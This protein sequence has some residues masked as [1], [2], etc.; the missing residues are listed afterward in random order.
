MPSPEEL[1]SFT[2]QMEGKKPPMIQG[3]PQPQGQ[4]PETL[5]EKQARLSALDKGA[6]TYPQ[7]TSFQDVYS[8]KAQGS[9]G[10]PL[11]KQQL[12]KDIESS[13]NFIKD[14]MLKGGVTDTT[15]KAWDVL[16]TRREGLGLPKQELPLEVGWKPP[17]TGYGA[18]GAVDL[19]N[20]S[21]TEKNLAKNIIEGKASIS[22]TSGFRDKKSASLVVQAVADEMGVPWDENMG[23][24][25]QKTRQD[26]LTGTAGKNVR[27]LNTAIGHLKSLKDGFDELNNSGIPIVNKPWNFIKKQ[28]AGN[29]AVTK[30]ETS[31]NAVA[32]ELASVFKNT[33][34]T[35]QEIESWKKTFNENMSPAQADAFI[36]K[37]IELMGTRIDT[38]NQ[39][40]NS[41]FEGIPENKLDVLNPKSKQILNGM[42][43]TQYTGGGSE[44]QV[45]NGVTYEKGSDGQWHKQK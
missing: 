18:M 40:W 26:F 6:I 45:V 43:F 21:P 15:K 28:F 3:L 13:E 44:T 25:R 19:T 24:I 35:D 4:M 30:V 10:D 1:N 16:Q 33:S 8:G 22:G 34:G 37:G 12:I 17:V 2:G 38:L 31:I 27:S 9:V 39:Q 14:A 36:K 23:K 11:K 29:P 42:G 32:G 7:G 41:A 20:I 5:T